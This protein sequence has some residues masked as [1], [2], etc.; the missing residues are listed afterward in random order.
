MR[1]EKEEDA[2]IK[3]RM[4]TSITA[5]VLFAALAIPV[6][7][8]AQ[9]EQEHNHRHKQH[10]YKL[11]D[12]GTFGG[13]SSFVNPPFNSVPALNSRGTIV[14]SSATSIPITSTSDGFVCGSPLGFV[15]ASFHAFQWRKGVVTD[16]G[17]LP[18]S[19]ENC[20]NAGAVNA[21]GESAGTSEI[22]EVDPVLGVKE[23]RAVIWKQGEIINLGTLG[24]RLS[25]GSVGGINN[26]GQVVGAATNAIPD[27]FSFLYLLA[28]N[29]D[30]TQTRAFLWQHRVM[31][32][33]GTL[34]GPDAWAGFVNQRSQIAGYSYT[35]STPNPVTGIPTQDP[36]LWEDGTMLDLGTLGG[37]FGY[38]AALNN[39]AQVI[40]SSSLAADPGACL[41]IGNI[42]NC[43]PFLWDQGSLIDL[44]TS[45]IGGNPQLVFAIND[46]GEIVGAAAFPNAP[47]DALLWRKGVATDL[48]HLDDCSSL[49][50]GINSHGQV[51]GGTF[52][53]ADGTQTHTRAFL[54]EN[55]SMVDLNTLIPHNS[56]FRMVEAEAINDRGEIAGNGVP[57]GVAPGD[58]NTLGHAFLL[59]PCDENHDDSECEDDGE[60]KAVA[61]GESSQRPNVIFPENVR[62]ILQQRLGSR[63]QIPGIGAWPLD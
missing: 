53:C 63:Y 1:K 17:A 59:I 19:E 49:A 6:H 27:P 14:G 32:D 7:V 29:P 25:V 37:A 44:F 48:G 41:G 9:D 52:S 30:G 16:L 61:R 50:F 42:A 12:M 57:P 5:M 39:R 21:S 54:W 58:V 4:L 36:F 15:P 31:Q 60:G 45:T 55:G 23:L 62:R 18:P 24:G 26:R 33:L 20:S 38:P 11:I 47:F 43:H 10:H 28:G 56:G 40:G 51:V 3:S 8:A 46:A 2:N 22:D 35:N 13:P 34:G